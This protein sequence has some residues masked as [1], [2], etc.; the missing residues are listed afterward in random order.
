MA[1]W[2]PNAQLPASAQADI[3]YMQ[4]TFVPMEPSLR[5]FVECGLL[6]R[7]TYALPDGTPM[8]PRDH[9]QLL[10]DA[11]GDPGAVAACFAARFLAAGGD[12]QEVEGQYRA[13][14]SGEYGACLYSTAPEYIRA[15]SGLSDAIT[16]LLAR[17][18]PEDRYWGMAVR[19]AVD[20][21]DALELPFAAHDDERF[22]GPSSRERLITAT[23]ERFPELWSEPASPSPASQKGR[24]A[25]LH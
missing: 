1:L 13:W 17:P 2:N 4:D 24:C 5:G 25:C 23:R 20:G 12:P 15:K 8:V 18:R 9:A 10:E 22:G 19:S 21:L 11:G 6:P 14:L 16:A 7:A 3:A